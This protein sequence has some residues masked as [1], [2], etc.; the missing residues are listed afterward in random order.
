MSWTLVWIG[1]ALVL[2]FHLG[3]MLMGLLCISR[4]G[5]TDGEQRSR[6]RVERR[7]RPC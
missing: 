6:L 5:A 2:G 7:T 1:G 3:V 4:D